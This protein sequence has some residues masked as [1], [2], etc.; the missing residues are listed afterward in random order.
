LST[1]PW[2]FIGY[3]LEGAA[4]AKFISIIAEANMNPGN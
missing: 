4:V 1:T 2:R 3:T